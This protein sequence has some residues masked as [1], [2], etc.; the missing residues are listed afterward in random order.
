MVFHSINTPIL[1]STSEARAFPVENNDSAN[2]IL[3]SL[4]DLNKFFHNQENP[5]PSN[6][7]RKVE[8]LPP[9]LDEQEILEPE[10]EMKPILFEE[11]LEP[12]GILE[13]QE[14]I[15]VKQL[16]EE[17][18][19]IIEAY[20]ELVKD[21]VSL[22]KNFSMQKGNSQYQKLLNYFS[23][24]VEYAYVNRGTFST[25]VNFPDDQNFSESGNKRKWYSCAEEVHKTVIPFAQVVCHASELALTYKDK[26]ALLSIQE[27]FAVLRPQ[28]SALNQ[29]EGTPSIKEINS[30]DKKI[31]G[32]YSKLVED[33]ASN[34]DKCFFKV[35]KLAGRLIQYPLEQHFS[36]QVAGKL[37]KHGVRIVKNA[38]SA[39][40]IGKACHYQKEWVYHLNPQIHIDHQASE[41]SQEQLIKE[42]KGFLNSLDQCKN[43]EE[44]KKIFKQRG[45]S[46]KGDVPN[47]FASWQQLIEGKRFR[48]YIKQSYY[49]SVGKRR[50]FNR[51]KLASHLLKREKD[52]KDK[53]DLSL[54]KI[55]GFITTT[56]EF[57]FE[58]INDFFAKQHIYLNLLE[59]PLQN[60]EEWELRI[61]DLEFQRSLAKQLVEHQETLDKLLDQALRQ[62]LLS[63]NAVEKES[64][65]YRWKENIASITLSLIQCALT[66]RGMRF[67]SIAAISKALSVDLSKVG[68]PGIGLIYLLSPETS[69]KIETLISSISEYFFLGQYK[70]HTYSKESYK[71]CFQKRWLL[72]SYKIYSQISRLKHVMLW[73]NVRLVENCIMGL[74]KKP[75]EE[76]SKYTEIQED[77]KQFQLKCRKRLKELKT[78]LRQLK[79]LDVKKIIQPSYGPPGP[80][81]EKG[82]P[83]EIIV[84]TLEGLDMELFPKRSKQF[85]EENFGIKLT[86]NPKDLKKDF[87]KFF[88]KDE[89]D[90]INSNRK[91]RF[92]YT[93]E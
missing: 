80:N 38:Y 40:K 35:V 53:V 27:R 69:L 28:I 30:F 71:L 17:D 15:Y 1:P 50:V 54:T 58:E 18:Q 59:F 90:F 66:F 51:D 2:D 44:V 16:S 79:L 34:L 10:V 37:C 85:I 4:S 25:I 8:V 62:S 81:D 23:A 70:P 46:I 74:P 75:L 76:Y 48:R 65:N 7:K 39:W 88:L 83:I 22:S 6:P 86:E 73:V 91:N 68:V 92:I 77:K 41:A 42:A 13:P 82:D 61:N 49:H 29:I 12:E 55:F 67:S 47:N 45:M 78:Q 11:D 3:K 20:V 26:E 93:R 9:G 60:K 57:T 24:R 72:F 33:K 89:M 32:L 21:F 14:E 84:N 19:K 63:K 31:N 56:R 64:L 43:V 5:I 36:K 52:F 87:E